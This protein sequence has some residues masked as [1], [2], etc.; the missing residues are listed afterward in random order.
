MSILNLQ[1]NGTIA[2]IPEIIVI[3]EF[4]VLWN[5][6]KSKDKEIATKEI[7]YI[8]LVSD[9]LSPYFN[10]PEDKRN[11]VVIKDIFKD[12]KWKED[13]AVRA[14]IVKY[15]EM[16]TTES[17]RLLRAARNAC[18][19]LT[20]YFNKVAF[21]SKKDDDSMSYI[22]KDVVS[23]LGSIGK[24]V[25]SL[26]KL[27]HKVKGEIKTSSKIIGGREVGAYER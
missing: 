14:A 20:E 10:Y 13:K 24:V 21:K 15:E 26:D 18:D 1:S 19:S 17:L 22:A 4:N 25:E 27:E 11:D 2:I 8:Y 16:N 7:L 9:F 5:R 23:N 3:P 6:D 12:S